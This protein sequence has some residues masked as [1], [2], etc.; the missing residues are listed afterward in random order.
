MGKQQ[1]GTVKRTGICTNGT[2]ATRVPGTALG[3]LSKAETDTYCTDT[4]LERGKSHLQAQK[5]YILE[6]NP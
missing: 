3:K 1:H 4:V 2:D 6:H 5:N